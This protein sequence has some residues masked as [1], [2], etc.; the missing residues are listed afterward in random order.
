M[1]SRRKG[2]ANEA[3]AAD[4]ADAAD[5]HDAA[6]GADAADA[7]SAACHLPG[8]P[9][10]LRC[11]QEL[12]SNRSHGIPPCCAGASIFQ[13]AAS[14]KN[15]SA[16]ALLATMTPEAPAHDCGENG[17]KRC[18]GQRPLGLVRVGHPS[19]GI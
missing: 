13:G 18:H 15:L 19:L 11:C 5:T 10:G 14:I 1:V 3:D 17:A 16:S 7:H 9:P 12:R 2:A 4:A 8:L 6:A